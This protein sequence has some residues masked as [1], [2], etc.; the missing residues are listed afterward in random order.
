MQQDFQD[1][2]KILRLSSVSF[3][4]IWLKLNPNTSKRLILLMKFEPKLRQ[5]LKLFCQPDFAFNKYLPLLWNLPSMKI[6]NHFEICLQWKFTITLK[7]AFHENL[8]SLWNLHSMKI[9]NHFE[10][11]LKWKFTI[12][13]KF[14]INENLQSLWKLWYQREC[15]SYATNFNDFGQNLNFFGFKFHQSST[16]F[17]QSWLTENL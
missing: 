1:F 9:C 5:K 4:Q 11:C 17:T 13:L 3:S 2:A 7:F 12:T 10:I 6:Y 15:L 14:A 16:D 8:Q